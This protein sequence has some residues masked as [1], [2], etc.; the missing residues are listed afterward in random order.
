MFEHQ[1]DADAFR[2]D[3][4]FSEFKNRPPPKELFDSIF[5]DCFIRIGCPPG[6]GKR[7]KAQIIASNENFKAY[8]VHWLNCSSDSKI[9]Y[10]F[11]AF[12]RRLNLF[13][14]QKLPSEI[15]NEICYKY[16]KYKK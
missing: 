14:K 12:A 10:A 16:H 13:P 11:K 4:Y 9:E 6:I 1:K 8:S 3:P 7:V 15:I 5:K 2:S